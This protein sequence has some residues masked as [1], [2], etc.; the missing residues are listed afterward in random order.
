M[1]LLALYLDQPLSHAKIQ[2]ALDITLIKGF[3]NGYYGGSQ[4][5][6]IALA[7]F[8]VLT[9]IGEDKKQILEALDKLGIT[10]HTEDERSHPYQDYPIMIDPKLWRNEKFGLLKNHFLLY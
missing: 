10:L 3:E 1:N 2:Y 4:M 6:H 7:P 8:G 9:L 5:L